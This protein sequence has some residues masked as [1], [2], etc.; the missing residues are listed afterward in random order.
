V[1][2]K[3]PKIAAA[4]L[5]ACLA[6]AGTSAER[7]QPRR[8]PP[9]STQEFL[10]DVPEYLGNVILG[11]PTDRTITASVLLTSRAA[12][13]R[14]TYGPHGTGMQ[15]KTDVLKLAAGE[16][17]EFALAELSPDT[18]YD[19][20]VVD[21]ATGTPLLPKDGVGTFRTAR[22]TGAKF[23]FTVQADSHLDGGCNPDIYKACLRN[24]LA[25]RPDFLVDLG[26]TFMTDKHP[27]RASA[28]RQYNAQ[29]YYFGLVGSAMPVFLTIG[30][31]DGEETRKR[32]ST[33]PDGLAVWSCEQRKKFFPNPAPGATP[34]YTGN[35]HPDPDAGDLEDYYAWAWG[36]ALF[37][38][39]DPYWP[40][41]DTH[42]GSDPWGMSLGRSQYDWLARTLL[43]SHA[44]YKFVFIHQ[45]VGGLDRAGRGGSEAAPLF[46]WGGKGLDG[47]TA[48]D[49]RRPGWGLPIHALL[50]RAGVSIV[51]HG[52]DHFYAHQQLDGITY[53][54]VPQPSHRL[55]AQ[56]QSA[57][58]GYK[59]GEFLQSSG[60]LRVTVA[61]DAVNVDYIRA[62]TPDMA[63]AGVNNGDVAAKYVVTA[64]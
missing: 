53:Q 49:Q 24:Q 38:V 36:D 37:V 10:T 29:R 28:L 23:V 7:Q 4:C 17:K 39:L 34:F 56:D 14:V 20:R 41:A 44:R 43:A 57:E 47:I 52:H 60:H 22:P 62:A 31:H 16:P 64:R 2:P 8:N 26:D 27:T 33:G 9:P 61:P 32:G 12:T 46:E 42:G 55:S 19:F 13:A 25:D 5:T 59:S 21:A 51:F 45:L 15:R 18:A 3:L 11:R 40:S 50:V 30:N 63:R 35:S 58:Y 6:L 48:F 1:N 54:L